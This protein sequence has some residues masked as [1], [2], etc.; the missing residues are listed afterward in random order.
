ME[1]RAEIY[2]RLKKSPIIPPDELDHAMQLV[3]TLLQACGSLQA[4]GV[5]IFTLIHVCTLP[6]RQQVSLPVSLVEEMVA[7][8][9]VGEMGLQTLRTLR[10]IAG[11]MVLRILFI[12]PTGM[13]VLAV[14]YIPKSDGPHVAV[15]C[16][17]TGSA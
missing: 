11:E 15:N 4:A 12:T 7:A 5:P 16:T 6:T 9:G 10:D 14:Q 1:P 17:T 8:M 13:S 3:D 2:E